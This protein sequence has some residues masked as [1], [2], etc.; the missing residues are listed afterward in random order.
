MRP[1]HRPADPLG[2]AMLAG[3]LLGLVAGALIGFGGEDLSQ[4]IV[5]PLVGALAGALLAGAP[6]A[7]MDI[8]R[9]RHLAREREIGHDFI[10]AEAH[11]VYDLDVAEDELTARRAD[12]ASAPRTPPG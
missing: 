3:A 12:G 5:T 2:A 4:P 11:R 10:R 7:L 8:G 9:S 1:H 6:F